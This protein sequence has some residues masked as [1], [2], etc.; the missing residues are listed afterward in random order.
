MGILRIHLAALQLHSSEP[1]TCAVQIVGGRGNDTVTI[2]L[3]QTAGLEPLY[4][5]RSKTQLDAAGE[6]NVIFQVTLAGPV[7]ASLH[8]QEEI[9]AIALAPDDITVRVL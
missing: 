5:A 8:A 1:T 3:L 4:T 9:S 7:T 6:G 2:R